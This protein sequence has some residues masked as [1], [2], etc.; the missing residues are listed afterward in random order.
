MNIYTTYTPPSFPHTVVS[1]RCSHLATSDGSPCGHPVEH[2]AEALAVGDGALGVLAP[3]I[4]ATEG[5]GV[6][7]PAMPAKRLHFLRC[8]QTTLVNHG[9][10]GEGREVVP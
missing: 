5:N 3:V 1:G 7:K 2:G 8:H 10:L 6:L 4:A 9:L